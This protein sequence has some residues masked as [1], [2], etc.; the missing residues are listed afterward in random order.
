MTDFICSLGSDLDQLGS[1]IVLSLVV[2]DSSQVQLTWSPPSDHSICITK[3]TIRVISDTVVDKTANTSGNMT[4]FTIMELSSGNVYNFSVAGVDKR[5]IIGL[6]S[7]PVI[8]DLSGKY[9]NCF[10]L[11]IYIMCSSRSSYKPST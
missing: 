7:E 8:I 9:E 10:T 11:Y 4:I 2:L 5:D 1:P 6:F 3:Y